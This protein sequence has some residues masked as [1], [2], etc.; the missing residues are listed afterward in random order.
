M[1]TRWVVI[2]PP[3]AATA[4]DEPKPPRARTDTM[5]STAHAR[6]ISLL[7]AP[8]SGAVRSD[9]DSF[10]FHGGSIWQCD[11]G[12]RAASLPSGCDAPIRGQGLDD[13]PQSVPRNTRR[14]RSLG[15]ARSASTQA[16][17]SVETDRRATVVQ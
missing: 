10:L 15:R 17:P 2:G 5:A 9:H 12:D 6:F 11:S 14:A 4:E 3:V 7:S 1:R 8:A 16:S 13:G